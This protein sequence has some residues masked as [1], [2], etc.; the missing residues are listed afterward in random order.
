MTLQDITNSVEYA[1]LQAL[2]QDEIMM[3]AVRKA[4][5]AGVYYQGVLTPDKESDPL[6]NFMMVPAGDP[7]ASNEK[8]GREVRAKYQAVCMI[9]N[10]FKEIY[11]I[12]DDKDKTK[13]KKNPAL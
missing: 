8:I 12:K 6:Q 1:K 2:A 3:E 4:I 13:A 5:L 7:D 10:G 11:K 9:E